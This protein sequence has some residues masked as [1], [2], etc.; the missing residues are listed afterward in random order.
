MGEEVAIGNHATLLLY[1]SLR[2]C[3]TIIRRYSYLIIVREIVL[4]TH[5]YVRT[6]VQYDRKKP[7]TVKNKRL[8]GPTPSSEVHY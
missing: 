4:K 7:R 8:D 3:H 6:I 2:T 1:T 5:I